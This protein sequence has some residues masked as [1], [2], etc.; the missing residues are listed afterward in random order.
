MESSVYLDVIF[1]KGHTQQMRCNK[2]VN[3]RCE[4]EENA[5]LV[6]DVQR[7]RCKAKRKKNGMSIIDLRLCNDFRWLRVKD[8][9]F[10]THTRHD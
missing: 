2:L 8:F 7:N 6:A 3:D 10:K 5:D 9:H 4:I 1:R